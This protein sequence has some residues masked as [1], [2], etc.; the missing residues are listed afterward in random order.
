MQYR[1]FVR[2]FTKAD[3]RSTVLA[4]S[5][6]SK[7]NVSRMAVFFPIPGNRAI[8]VTASSTSRVGKFIAKIFG[9]KW[10]YFEER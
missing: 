9:S 1:V 2:K 4:S 6:Y 8:S 7:C 3:A 10:V 5:A